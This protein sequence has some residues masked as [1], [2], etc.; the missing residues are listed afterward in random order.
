MEETRCPC[1]ELER[2]IKKGVKSLRDEKAPRCV[3]ADY[4]ND[5]Y[6]GL[7]TGCI[8]CDHGEWRGEK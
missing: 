3:V 8:N 4:K 7:W 5:M 2:K 6:S 1:L